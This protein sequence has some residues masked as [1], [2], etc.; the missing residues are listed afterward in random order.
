MVQKNKISLFLGV[1]LSGLLP[2]QLHAA[3]VVTDT[4]IQLGDAGTSTSPAEWWLDHN[5]VSPATDP[6]TIGGY[7]RSY[8]HLTIDQNHS[9]TA[10]NGL[11]VGPSYSF[12]NLMDIQTGGNVS[13][14]GDVRV[15]TGSISYY[16]TYNG[17]NISGENATLS[18]SGVLDM[19]NGYNAMNNY[20]T[21]TDGGKAVVED[22]FSLYYHWAYGNNW[23]ELGGGSLFLA[24]DKTSDFA[25]GNGIL[26]S[27]KVW[28]DDTNAFERV[29]YYSST[30]LYSTPY[31]NWLA[32]D[33]IEDAAQAAALG[34]SDDFIGYTILHDI[35]PVPEPATLLLF[36]TGLAGLVST[37]IRRKNMRRCNE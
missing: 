5:T 17:I 3:G 6:F 16:S 28:D 32:V 23:L 18:I 22:A 33:Y 15:G 1:A 27:I 10:S 36:G 12:R 29:S 35:N 13:V 2:L 37:R 8:N 20:L 30:T 9:F 31:L 24:G 4:M 14:T 26:S 34:Y 7:A 25:E 19:Y 21:L 11:V